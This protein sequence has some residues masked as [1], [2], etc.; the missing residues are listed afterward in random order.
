M[1]LSSVGREIVGVQVVVACAL[2][3][4]VVSVQKGLRLED[5]LQLVVWLVGLGLVEAVKEKREK[6]EGGVALLH[7]NQVLLF[8][9]K[10]PI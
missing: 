8:L 1:L 4:A 2:G 7:L 5:G 10:T 9:V 3:Q 6:R